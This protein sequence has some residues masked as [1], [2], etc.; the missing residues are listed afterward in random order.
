[1]KKIAA[2]HPDTVVVI[3]PHSVLYADYI[4]ISPGKSAS[5]NFRQFGESSVSI[6]ADY[7]EELVSKI[8][9]M[10][11][12]QGIYAGPMGEKQKSLDHGT[13]VPLYF[14]N[15]EYRDYKLVRI[16]VSGLSAKEHYEFGLCVRQA[17]ETLGRNAVIIASGD[18]SH[19][20]SDDGPYHFTEE[21]PA[22]DRAM[23]EA[24]KD[25]D[26]L[27]FLNFE[28]GF[29]ELAG[30]CGLRSFIIMAGIL[31]GLA[32]QTEFL[33][34]EAPFGVGYAVAAF[35]VIGSDEQ[36]RFLKRFV[37][38][39]EK[40]LAQKKEGED[41]FVRL[42]R[43]SL[44]HYVKN[45]KSLQTKPELSPQLAQKKAGVFVSLKKDGK[46]RGCIGTTS[47]TTESIGDEIIQNA[48]S[49]GVGDPRFEPVNEEELP[50]LVY[51][52]DVLGEAEAID[53]KDFL[54]P[55]RYGVIVESGRKKA[56]LLPALEGIK[57]IEQQLSVVLQKAGIDPADP[58]SISRFEVVR[59]K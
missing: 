39:Q 27:R 28:N 24:I 26:F 37:E 31:D 10:A 22:F 11:T 48:V 30:E 58:Y 12:N 52:V 46:L 6:T 33:S 19:C 25:A 17:I 32:L 36:R 5:G 9:E 44:E 15:K 56:L 29:C 55:S 45:R 41:E 51:S 18:L 23:V 54:D 59:H 47:P 40:A 42:A 1:S 14:I 35:S 34:Y 20:L 38:E 57:T 7:D 50:W 2:L 4:H 21:G 53:S 16:S 8:T 3:S 49:A 43:L 13:L